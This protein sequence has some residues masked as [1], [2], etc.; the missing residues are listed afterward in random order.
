MFESKLD[1]V[2]RQ[3]QKTN[4]LTS[5]IAK[6]LIAVVRKWNYYMQTLLIV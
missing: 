2:V 5:E 6:T 1:K 4:A 3:Y